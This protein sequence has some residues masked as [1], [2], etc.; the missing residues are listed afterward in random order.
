MCCVRRRSRTTADRRESV[1]MNNCVIRDD[2][3]GHTNAQPRIPAAFAG[4]R[5]PPHGVFDISACY[6]PRTVNHYLRFGVHIILLYGLD[7]PCIDII[8]LYFIIVLGIIWCNDPPVT[9]C[10]HTRTTPC[11]LVNAVGKSKIGD[12]TRKWF[13]LDSVKK[14][15]TIN[16]LFSFFFFFL[17][18]LTL[19]LSYFMFYLSLNV[20]FC[21][22]FLIICI[23]Q[24][25]IIGFI[26]YRCATLYN[27]TKLGNWLIASN[28]ECGSGTYVAGH[29][30]S[31]PFLS[32]F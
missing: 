25:K 24:Y 11:R 28:S 13:G 22:I 16:S 4:I 14:C 20:N 15:A 6:C 32:Q 21:L 8:L 10:I 3:S 30:R 23:L 26:I 29:L 27:C 12:G 7:E 5:G 2:H 18:V 17:H 1:T 9:H 31:I 19:N